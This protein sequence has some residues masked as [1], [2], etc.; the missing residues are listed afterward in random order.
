MADGRR[1]RPLNRDIGATVI[2]ATVVTQPCQAESWREINSHV[3][4]AREYAICVI[5]LQQDTFLWV[6]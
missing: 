6:F 2:G 5:F 1:F 3:T 4:N